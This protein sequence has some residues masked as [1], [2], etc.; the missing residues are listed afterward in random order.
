MVSNLVKLKPGHPE[1]KYSQKLE[2][3]DLGS[4]LIVHIIII[5]TLF[6]EDNIFD[7]DASLT[8]GPQLTNIGM[9]LKK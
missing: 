8:N 4:R 7:T 1:T 3:A 6:Q 2:I 9:L 5:I